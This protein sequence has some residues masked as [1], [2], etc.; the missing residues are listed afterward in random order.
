MHV[1]AVVAGGGASEKAADIGY[2]PSEPP[3]DP[4]GADGSILVASPD[5]QGLRPA[6]EVKGCGGGV[7]NGAGLD[8]NGSHVLAGGHIGWVLLENG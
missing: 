1:V 7:N 8:F 6:V 2:R 3:I 5:T 4:E